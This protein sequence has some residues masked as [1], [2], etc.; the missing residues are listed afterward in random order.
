M[1]N[2]NI[3]KK[4][5]IDISKKIYYIAYKKYYDI[6][7]LDYEENNAKF[8][9][10]DYQ[11]FDHGNYSE[12]F[13]YCSNFGINLKRAI[14]CSS[15]ILIYMQHNISIEISFG[16]YIP[17]FSHKLNLMNFDFNNFRYSISEFFKGDEVMKEVKVIK[18]FLE[19]Q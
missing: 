14:N 13:L 19:D 8:E 10:I 18:S 12:Y 9:N 1:D 3:R 2:Y 15:Y 7:N 17:V 5:C 6:L 16:Y 11:Y 4:I